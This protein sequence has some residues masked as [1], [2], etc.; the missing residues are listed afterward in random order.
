[1]F[2]LPI[3]INIGRVYQLYEESGIILKLNNLSNISSSQITALE[4][5]LIKE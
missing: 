3:I 4:S 1:M 2:L 5:N